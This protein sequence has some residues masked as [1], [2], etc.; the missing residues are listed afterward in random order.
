MVR[1]PQRQRQC[2]E[3]WV[4]VAAGREDSTT[5]HVQIVDFENPA[6][7]INNSGPV[8]AAHASGTDM[9]SADWTAPPQQLPEVALPEVD[10]ADAG[11]SQSRIELASPDQDR[12]RQPRL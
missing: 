8:V 1:E 5:D 4:G 7:G 10:A 9:V 3:C 6:F 11:V 2:G 12:A